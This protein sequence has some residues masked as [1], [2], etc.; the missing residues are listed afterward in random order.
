[1]FVPF[2]VVAVGGRRSVHICLMRQLRKGFRSLD[3]P[4]SSYVLS[5]N[6]L[7]PAC[8]SRGC[9][10]NHSDKYC[11]GPRSGVDTGKNASGEFYFGIRRVIVD[12]SSAIG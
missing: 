8:S 4:R 1:M 5:K 6:E 9:R 7:W 12:G 3:H 11:A 2:E 10:E